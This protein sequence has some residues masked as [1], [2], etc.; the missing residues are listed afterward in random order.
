MIDKKNT[1]FAALARPLIFFCVLLL[2]AAAIYLV[3]FSDKQQA[4]Q[5]DF[6]EAEVLKLV[7]IE[8]YSPPPPVSEKNV[9][10]VSRQP[11]A[12]EII[13]ETEK[14]V[15]KEKDEV[16]YLPQHKISALPVLPAREILS[17][18]VYPPMALKQGIEAVVYLELVIDSSG[19]IRKVK[20]L[21]DPG[22]GFAEAAVK[23]LEGI[24][25]I[26]ASANGKN[27]AVRYRYP[28]KFTLN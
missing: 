5:V 6:R 22:H 7:D 20:V 13:V 9:I 27:C 17:R 21:K 14:L 12:S 25:C 26:P 11:Q 16:E 10:K 19:L 18:V 4:E 2:H 28:V 3:N 1:D 24:C 15:Q 8:E 23:A